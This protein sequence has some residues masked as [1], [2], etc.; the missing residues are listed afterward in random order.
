MMRSRRAEQPPG[1]LLSACFTLVVLAILALA[2]TARA[3]D[4]LL[5][6]AVRGLARPSGE[7]VALAVS[8]LGASGDPRSLGVLEAVGS[9]RVDLQACKLEYSIVSPK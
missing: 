5:E 9:S 8:A 3:D 7:E 2:G 4:A 6:S 1:T